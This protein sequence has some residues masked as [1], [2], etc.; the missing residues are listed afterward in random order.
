MRSKTVS[1]FAE[2]H[3]YFATFQQS[4]WEFDQDAFF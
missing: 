1:N 2:E 4:D 3:Q